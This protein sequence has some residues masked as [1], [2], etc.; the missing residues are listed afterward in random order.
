MPYVRARGEAI[1]I[2]MKDVGFMQRP[3]RVVMLGFG[4]A[5]APVLQAVFSSSGMSGREGS[6]PLLE[7][8][9]YDALTVPCHRAIA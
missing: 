6:R 1:G 8:P 7:K 9:G 3:E 4:V 2:G 5:L